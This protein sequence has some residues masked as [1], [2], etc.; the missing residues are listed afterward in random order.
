LAAV[1]KQARTDLSPGRVRP[2]E[3]NGIEALD[4]YGT[5]A[6]GAVDSEEL[7]RD[8]R[9][10]HLLEGNPRPPGGARVPE[11]GVPIFLG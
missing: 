3:P 10:P 7:P 1:V 4:L 8:L 6:A 9:Q 11:D 5:A 2:I